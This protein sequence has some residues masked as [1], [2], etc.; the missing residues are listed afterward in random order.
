[1][2]LHEYQA[3]DL[4]ARYG[5]AVPQGLLASSPEAAR[6]AAKQLGTEKVVVKAQIH[7]GARGKA[8][9]VKLVNGPDEAEDRLGGQLQLARA[10]PRS[11]EHTSELQSLMRNSYA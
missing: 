7:A 4:F 1:M 11:E 2:N 8:G 10:V 5:I 9:G 6:A 3:K